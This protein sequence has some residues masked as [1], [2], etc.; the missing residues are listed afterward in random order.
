MIKT[1]R[2]PRRRY[3][4]ETKLAIVRQ[5]LSGEQSKAAISRQHDI[6]TNMLCRW[7]REYQYGAHWLPQDINVPKV[8][9][10]MAEV[11]VTADVTEKT[12]SFDMTVDL[13]SGHRVTLN[14]IDAAALKTIFE[15]LS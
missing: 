5:A 11:D 2:L 4:S 1:T 6:N 12:E 3:S 13:R 10:V 14:G 9:P 7:I 8:Y 15:V